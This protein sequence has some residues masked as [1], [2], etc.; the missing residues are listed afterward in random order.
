MSDMTTVLNDPKRLSAL[1]RLGLL[2]TP[3]EEVF[4][5]LTRLASTSLQT[6]IALLTLVD[7][8]RQFFKS[9]VGLPE[10]V[11]TKRETPLSYS[12]CKHA[13][14]SGSPLVIGTVRD[15]P[16]VRDN[17]SIPEFGVVAYAGI[18]LL[19]T[20]G[21]ALGTLCVIDT[22]PREWTQSEIELLE[23]LAAAAMTEIEQRLTDTAGPSADSDDDD[24][25]KAGP[26]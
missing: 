24:G 26:P 6:P 19:T 13:V 18:P 21:D 8:D 20:E 11:A 16:L 17:L 22:R 14:A 12:F 9:A 4:D 7:A 15:L 23:D 1:R 5:R 10:P 3:P 25:R 2:D